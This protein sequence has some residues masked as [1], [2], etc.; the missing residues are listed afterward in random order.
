MIPKRSRRER[1]W[2]RVWGLILEWMQGPV[3]QQ[4]GREL[5]CLES[6]LVSSVRV[7][8]CVCACRGNKATF[9]GVKR[10]SVYY[11]QKVKAILLKTIDQLANLAVKFSLKDEPNRI[12][13]LEATHR[14]LRSTLTSSTS[15]PPVP[16]HSML[17]LASCCLLHPVVPF[18][19]TAPQSV[20]RYV[21][22]PFR[23]YILPL[24]TVI[25]F[26]LFY[27][28]KKKPLRFSLLTKL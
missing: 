4:R 16:Q 7:C 27:C 18:G 19:D 15:E 20:V 1:I 12:V 22:F 10:V 26:M 8:V 6:S 5:V 11:V 14:N 25:I 17:S 21:I 24:D 9:T 2:A 13:F 3:L 28:G 23:Y